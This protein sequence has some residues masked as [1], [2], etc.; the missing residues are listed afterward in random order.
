MR[1]VISLFLILFVSTIAFGQNSL[2]LKNHTP[3]QYSTIEDIPIPDGYKRIA[4]SS[5][6]FGSYLRTLPLKQNNNTVY[7]YNGQQKGNQKAQFAVVKMDVGKRDLQ[8]CADAIMRLR[9]EYLFQENRKQ[10]I[11]FNFVN[12]MQVDYVKYAAGNRMRVKGNKTKWVKTAKAS[13]TYR[14]FRNYMNL[15]F[16]YAG[17]ASL[18]KELK[19]VSSVKGIALGDV[20]IIG[21]SPGHAVIV[22]D[23]AS[24]ASGKKIFML[25]QSYM[26]AQEIHVLRNPKLLNSPWYFLEDEQQLQTPEYWFRSSNLR[27]F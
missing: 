20:F 4:C 23:V 22:V 11:H 25:A 13:N 19:P 2:E 16:S 17:T 3:L 6:S 26:P 7:L 5:S 27:R 24:N 21:G 15:I 18:V 14:T 1:A 8:Q 12:G 9:A 10:E